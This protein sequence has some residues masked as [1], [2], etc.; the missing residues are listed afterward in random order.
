MCLT[1]PE[2]GSFVVDFFVAGSF[3]TKQATEKLLAVTG[4]VVRNTMLFVRSTI[5]TTT[6][7]CLSKGYCRKLAALPA[8]RT[9]KI[10][11]LKHLK[12]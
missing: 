7:F 11:L 3:A 12:S 10:P 2:R 9:A 5:P 8:R 6:T 4:L 1:L